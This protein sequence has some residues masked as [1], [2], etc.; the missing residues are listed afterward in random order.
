LLASLFGMNTQYLPIVGY[1]HDF[2]IIFGI[3]L[4]ATIGMLTIFKI[5]KWV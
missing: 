2:W 3:M 5:K 4:I 1:K